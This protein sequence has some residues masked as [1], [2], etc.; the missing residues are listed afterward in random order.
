MLPLPGGMG[1]TERL[2]LSIFQ[3]AFGA[4]T[5]PAMI[6]SRGFSFYIQLFIC[7]IMTVVAYIVV[8]WIPN[9]RKT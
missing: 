3:G 8:F 7:A 5:L 9:K 6:L 2:F 1:I 4:L